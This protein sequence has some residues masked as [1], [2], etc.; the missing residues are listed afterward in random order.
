MRGCLKW[1][2]D[3]EEPQTAALVIRVRDL[4]FRPD[5]I[6]TQA[7]HRAVYRMAPS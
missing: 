5:G 2:W 1:V 4:Y 6:A 3:R 7:G